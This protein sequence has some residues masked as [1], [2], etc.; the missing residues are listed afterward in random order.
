MYAISKRSDEAAGRAFGAE[1]EGRPPDRD[2]S[3]RMAT[4]AVRI[5]TVVEQIALHWGILRQQELH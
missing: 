5:G 4:H 1:G 3:E 2:L